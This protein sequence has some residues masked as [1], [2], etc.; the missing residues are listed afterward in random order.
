MELGIFQVIWF[1]LWGVLWAGYFA[2]D[3]FDLGAGILL[4]LVA[5]SEAQKR[6]VYNAIGPFWDANEVWLI[7]AGGATF[8]AFPRAYAIMFSGLYS[9][10]LLLLFCLILRGVAVEFRG[11]QSDPAWRRRW[12]TVFTLSSLLAALLLGVAFANIF[13]GV[14]IDETGTIRGGLLSLLNP[15]GLLGGLFFVAMFSLHGALWLS[16]R[17]TGDLEEASERTALRLWRATVV[18]AVVFMLIS[19]KATGIWENYTKYPSLL[20]IPALAVASLV[21]ILPFTKQKK[22]LAAFLASMLFVVSSTFWGIAGL[23]PNLLPSSI[24]RAY[25][26]TI[27]NSSSSLL[28]LK[29]MTVVAFV[30]VPVMLCYKFWVYKTFSGKLTEEG[31]SA[32]DGY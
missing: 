16:Y 7:T 11:K 12:D 21:A 15:Y 18:L 8:A 3:G 20:I 28:T 2:L 9:A 13:K 24:N 14:P 1:V 10:L 6:M 4:P 30:F 17:S 22:R 29:V 19:A 32:E 23:F 5:E 31:I 27:Y 25:S 26:V